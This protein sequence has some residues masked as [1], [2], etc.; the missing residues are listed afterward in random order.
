MSEMAILTA[1]LAG[2]DRGGIVVALA[3]QK[4]LENLIARHFLHATNIPVKR[5]VGYRYTH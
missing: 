2:L 5:G 4:T 1:T 3:A